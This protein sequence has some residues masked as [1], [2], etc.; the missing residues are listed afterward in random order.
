M[1]FPCQEGS[2]FATS[3]C[4]WKRT[5]KKMTSAL[6]ASASVVGVIPGPI[7]VAADAKL[8]GSRVVAT[9]TA[10]PLRAN[11]LARVWPISPKPM[12]A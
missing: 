2:A 11:A 8:C 3:G 4:D 10:M 6:T 1:I 5:A 7:A 12:I 9:D